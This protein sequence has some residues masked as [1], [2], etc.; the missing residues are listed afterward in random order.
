M[1]I[2]LKRSLMAVLCV[3]GMSSFVACDN[4]DDKPIVPPVVEPT[5]E[6]GSYTGTMTY[7]IAEVPTPTADVVPEAVTYEASQSSVGIDSIYFA[8]FP[9]TG[10]VTAVAGE[11]LAGDIIKALGDV[12]YAVYYTAKAS[13]DGMTMTLDPKSLNLKLGALG[14]VTVEVEAVTGAKYV[15]ASKTMTFSI[16]AKNVKV[17]GTALPGFQ[18][19]TLSFEATKK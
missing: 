12:K 15:T 4:E 3:A 9:V 2:T 17:G 14:D 8:K 10:L 18:P 11:E 7:T 5:A 19:I 6:N 1:K 16:I 13:T